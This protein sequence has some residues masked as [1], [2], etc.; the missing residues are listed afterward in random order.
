MLLYKYYECIRINI[1]N[2]KGIYYYLYNYITFLNFNMIVD[3]NNN[4]II[5]NIMIDYCIKTS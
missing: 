5:C 3:C 4:L 2:L 1:Y